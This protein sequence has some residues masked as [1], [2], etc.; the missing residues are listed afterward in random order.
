MA[1]SA[2]NFF[3]WNL[4]Q[5]FRQSG[6]CVLNCFQAAA[7]DRN[8]GGCCSGVP[9]LLYQTGLAF[10]GGSAV[11]TSDKSCH[12]LSLKSDPSFKHG[13]PY[14][15]CSFSWKIFNLKKS[16]CGAVIFHSCLYWWSTLV[17]EQYQLV[18]WQCLWVGGRVVSNDCILFPPINI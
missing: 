17:T 18:F 7:F 8:L 12:L 14:I 15:F 16:Y 5:E 3:G 1:K 11:E 10:T 9:S 6:D 4:T 13:E 2:Y